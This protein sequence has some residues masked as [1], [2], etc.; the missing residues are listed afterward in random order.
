MLNFKVVFALLIVTPSTWAMSPN[1]PYRRIEAARLR[2]DRILVNRL[3]KPKSLSAVAIEAPAPAL[4][5]PSEA[6][7]KS[8]A[9]A[10]ASKNVSVNLEPSETV[11]E[12][13]IRKG[14]KDPNFVISEDQMGPLTYGEEFERALALSRV[15]E[16]RFEGQ[17]RLAI[18]FPAT[19]ANT[20]I[21][22]ASHLAGKVPVY[23]NFTRTNESVQKGLQSIGVTSILTTRKEI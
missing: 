6:W 16:D 2:C 13:I 22:L 5:G 10:D 4:S 8:A 3:T 12:A 1:I 20:T 11:T 14:L 15:L 17:N 23:V 9:L 7:V 18:L 19:A 21:Y